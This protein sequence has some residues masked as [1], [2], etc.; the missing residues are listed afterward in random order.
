MLASV[1]LCFGVVSVRALWEG[2]DALRKGNSS[3]ARG[4]E[5]GAVRWWR[6][7]ARWYLPMAPHVAGAYEKLRGLAKAAEQ[8][9]KRKIA[10][11]AW[12]GIRSSVRATR[13]V[14]T[15]YA[16][17]LQEADA[18][19][20]RL[21]AEQEMAEQEATGGAALEH[22][23]GDLAT[24]E[25]WHARLLARDDMPSVGWSIFALLGLTMWIGGGFAFAITGLDDSDLLRPKAAA[26]SGAAIGMGLLI[27]LLGLHL[28]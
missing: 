9:G 15:P 4:D 7:S 8:E 25:A 18:H 17:Y 23:A 28:A 10:L 26:Y 14:Y 20:A 11:D 2:R 22:G 21:M 13:S 19:I 24:A 27:W 3:L 6:R 1:A 12:T 5:A 16:S